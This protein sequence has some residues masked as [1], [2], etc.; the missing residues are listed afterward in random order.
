MMQI[1]CGSITSIALL[2]PRQSEKA[3]LCDSCTYR[4]YSCSYRRRGKLMSGLL[5]KRP[6]SEYVPHRCVRPVHICAS[7][8]HGQHPEEDLVHQSVQE[9]LSLG[10]GPTGEG[11]SPSPNGRPQLPPGGLLRLAGEPQRALSYVYAKPV[12]HRQ[13]C[14]IMLLH[15]QA[16]HPAFIYQMLC[17]QGGLDPNRPA[18]K[19]MPLC[20]AAHCQKLRCCP[21]L[22]GAGGILP[23]G[24]VLSSGSR[25]YIIG[26]VL[27][28][29]SN[30]VAYRV[31]GRAQV[32]C[33]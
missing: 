16:C 13:A 14:T 4:C 10:S 28:T 8:T 11:R 33:N 25:S 29:G 22:T 3:S 21:C 5:R 6:V 24:S 7:S 15:E 30:A 9:A 19:S 17:L 20:I 32:R 12:L 23:P 26:E 31:S 27:G 18:P 1:N 2:G